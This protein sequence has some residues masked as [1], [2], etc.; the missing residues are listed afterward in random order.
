MRKRLPRTLLHTLPLA[1]LFALAC[2]LFAPAAPSSARRARR[3]TQEQEESKKSPPPS[4]STIYGRAVYDDTNRPVRRARVMLVDETGSRPEF[5]A[6]TDSDGAFR[7]EH[8]REGSYLVFVDAPGIISPIGFVNFSALRGS[9]PPEFTE[10]RKFLDVVDVD[11]KQDSRMTVR[12]RRGAALGGKVTYADGDPAVNV[13]VNVMR[14]DAS[15]HLEKILT[16]INITALSGL[17]TDDRGIF[18]VSGLPPSEYVVSVSEQAEHGDGGGE[19]M[20]SRDPTMGV[21]E[22]LSRQQFLMTYYPSVT[23]AKEAVVIKADAGVERSDIDITIPE[24]ALH[25]VGGVVRGRSDKRPVKGAKVT[26]VRRDEDAGG[27]PAMELYNAEGYI[28][29]NATVTDAEG[30]WEFK[31]IP[32]G[33][34]TIV[35]KPNEEFEETTVAVA[36]MNAT[37]SSNTSY[38]GNMNGGYRR[39]QRKKGY[40]PGHRDVQVIESDLSDVAVELIDGGR[41]SG[42]VTL[43][44]AKSGS[45]GSVS[46]R[47]VP[48]GGVALGSEENWTAY[49]AEGRFEINGLPAGKYFMQFNS[50]SED[51][52]LY[53]KSMT[54][55]GKDL[56]RE[57]LEIGEGASADDVRIV[58]SNNPSKLRVRATGAARK[59][60]AG[61]V[62][63]VLVPAD[64]AGWSPYAQ[65]F[66]CATE[67]DG[68]C[69]ITAPPGDYRVVAIPPGSKGDSPEGELKRRAPVA[70]RV[71]LTAGETK[72]F[73]V[74]VSEK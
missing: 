42:T 39:P 15:G 7:I 11:G 24:R 50:F 61:G 62:G 53:A 33:P 36:N 45:Y 6:L 21:L 73:E 31:E 32:E 67:D 27:E 19:G 37:M 13:S 41:V 20:G 49:A 22:G 30:H 4:N 72:E 35:V 64:V 44:G 29:G 23:R 5:N 26:I 51:G 2:A 16:G 3:A 74:V 60:A 34:Y 1:A 25:L 69:E 63:V 18:R 71:T 54:W 43:E 9:G 57:P 59:S 68:T 40:A 14:R 48:D 56:M 58:M 46:L 38:D 52:R 55:N 47:R 70:P 28:S 66:A 12:A 8:V 10:A 65:Q 17:R